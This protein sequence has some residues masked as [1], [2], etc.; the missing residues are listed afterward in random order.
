MNYICA[1]IMK[2]VGEEE[3]AFWLLAQIVEDYMPGACACAAVYSVHETCLSFSFVIG[4]FSADM[5]E[6]Q[7]SSLF[8]ISSPFDA[9]ILST[10]RSAR[11]Q[12]TGRR[13]SP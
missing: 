10:G 9:L 2:N 13:I 8:L 6:S 12:A 3:D 1:H 7:A 11:F 5:V 4:Y